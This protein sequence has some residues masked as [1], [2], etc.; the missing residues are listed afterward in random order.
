MPLLERSELNLEPE[1]AIELIAAIPEYVERFAEAFPDQPEVS[2][3]NLASALAA[4]QRT[5]VSNRSQYDAYLRG[6][7][8]AVDDELVEGM[9]RFAEMGCDACHVP[10]LFESEVFANRGVPPLDG[11]EDDGL[12]EVTENIE[13]A[14]KFRTPSLRNV[15]VTE[16]YFHNGS[17]PFLEDAVEHELA[18]TGLPFDDEDVRLIV[19]FIDDALRDESRFVQRPKRVPSGL[20][21]PLDGQ[22]F[23]FL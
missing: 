3:D 9:H 6:H 13:D 21:V 15:T 4:F 18:Q 5:I 17:V 19:R 7:L 20:P 16:P 1:V 23:P 11:I 12:A 8:G 14:G 22:F 10:P 2:L